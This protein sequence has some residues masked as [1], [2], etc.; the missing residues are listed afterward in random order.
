MMTYISKT[1]AERCHRL[2]LILQRANHAEDPHI[3]VYDGDIRYDF[4]IPSVDYICRR[5]LSNG[6]HIRVTGESVGYKKVYFY[7]L[8]DKRTGEDMATRKGLTF[9]SEKEAYGAAID[10]ALDVLETIKK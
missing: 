5:F 9:Y 7:A 2:G 6:I 1:Q 8:T 4:K 3:E 10:D